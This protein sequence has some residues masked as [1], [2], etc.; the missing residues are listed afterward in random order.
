MTLMHRAMY[1]SAVFQKALLMADMAHAPKA[2]DYNT[3]NG[4]HYFEFTDPAT[5]AIYDVRVKPRGEKKP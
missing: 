2:T 5:G 4:A 3:M 1:W